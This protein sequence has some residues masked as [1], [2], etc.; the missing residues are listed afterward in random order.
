MAISLTIPKVS[1]PVRVNFKLRED[2]VK[3][4][5]LYVKAAKEVNPSCDES[6]VL[7]AILEHHL[8]RDKEFKKWLK[9]Y[10]PDADSD[11]TKSSFSD[12]KGVEKKEKTKSSDF[13][14]GMSS[15]IKDATLETS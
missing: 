14:S 12:I 5:N 2:L 4:F 8:K 6:L 10:S 9:N 7:E 13:Q 1:E 11:D 15:T 3:N